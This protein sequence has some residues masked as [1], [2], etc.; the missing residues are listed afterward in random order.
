MEDLVAMQIWADATR[1]VTL[2][3]RKL[4]APF[5]VLATIESDT[6]S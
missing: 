3:R 6:E 4:Q 5:E 2:R 1:V